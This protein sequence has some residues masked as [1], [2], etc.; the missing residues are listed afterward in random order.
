MKISNAEMVA[1]EGA[2]EE[3]GIEKQL[4][5]QFFELEAKGRLDKFVTDNDLESK[6]LVEQA[7]ALKQYLESVV[8]DLRMKTSLGGDS[9]AEKNERRVMR[10]LVEKIAEAL[11]NLHLVENIGRSPQES[12]T[13]LI[14]S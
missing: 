6:T 10:Q 12:P 14:N 13:Y 8:D 9:V 11:Y 2:V 4:Q 1:L 3:G 5:G 7:E